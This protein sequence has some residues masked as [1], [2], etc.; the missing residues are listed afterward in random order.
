MAAVDLATVEQV[1]GYLGIASVADDALLGRLITAASHYIQSW[2]NREFGQSTYTDRVSGT[3]GHTLLFRNYPVTA[4]SAVVLNDQAITESTSAYAAGYVWDETTIS[5]RGHIFPWGRLNISITYTAGFAPDAIPPEITQACIE[6]VSM[7]YRERDRVGLS[8][9]G[10]AGETISYSQK[11]MQ[12]SVRTILNN[13]R[14][15]VPN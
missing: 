9:K 1:K 14:K 5:L 2:L 6:L 8:S 10:L 7:R 4:V 11:D 13:W 15:V 12:D 3:G